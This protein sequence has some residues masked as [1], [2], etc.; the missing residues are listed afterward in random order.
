VTTRE[1]EEKE[2]TEQAG[3]DAMHVRIRER[4]DAREAALTEEQRETLRGTAEFVKAHVQRSRM[5]SLD[6]VDMLARG[7][8]SLLD[9]RTPPAE[10]VFTAAQVRERAKQIIGVAK[11]EVHNL[12]GERR[13]FAIKGRAACEG[14]QEAMELLL[15]RLGIP[16]DL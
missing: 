4:I 10:P 1:K 16:L 12:S 6:E 13:A 2:E 3:I 8:L 15:I 5:A 14:M 11:Q 7:V 9:E